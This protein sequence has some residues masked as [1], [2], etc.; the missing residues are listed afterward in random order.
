MSFLP[1]AVHTL[2]H[3]ERREW[4][5]VIHRAAKELLVH[6]ERVANAVEKSDRLGCFREENATIQGVRQVEIALK[7]VQWQRTT[8]CFILRS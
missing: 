5:I 1:F 4:T 3:V 2:T 8:I 7:V 6:T